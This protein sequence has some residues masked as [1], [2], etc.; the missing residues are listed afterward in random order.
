M[1]S[2]CLNSHCSAAFRY[3][4]QG[5]L[6][7]VDFADV[8]KKQSRKSRGLATSVR[9]QSQPV[10]HFWLCENCAKTL[11]VEL[12]DAGEIRLVSLDAPNLT[13]VTEPVVRLSRKA[14]AS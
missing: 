14:R 1:L 12:S 6:F 8:G 4:G 7:R 11:T 3:L 13:V 5:K 10:E 2:K 9:S